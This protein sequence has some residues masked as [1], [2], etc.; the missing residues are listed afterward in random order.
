MLDPRQKYGFMF[1]PFECDHCK[2]RTTRFYLVS[3]YDCEQKCV[4]SSKGQDRYEYVVLNELRCEVP[5][6]TYCTIAH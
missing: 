4:L 2:I 3:K 1:F 6:V 5:V